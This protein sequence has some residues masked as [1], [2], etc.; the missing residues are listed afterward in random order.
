[1]VGS[2][3]RKKKMADTVTTDES[4]K[5][6]EEEEGKLHYQDTTPATITTG[7]EDK[8]A[9]IERLKSGFRI[10]KPQGTFLWPSS[11]SSTTPSPPSELVLRLHD[12]LVSPTPPSVSSSTTS[13]PLLPTSP[14][15]L[16]AEKRPVTLTILPT[17]AT[18]PTHPRSVPMI[19]PRSFLNLNEVPTNP[20]IGDCNRLYSGISNDNSDS[21]PSNSSAALTYKR[22]QHSSVLTPSDSA[23]IPALPVPSQGPGGALE[24]NAY[25][26][27]DD[28]RRVIMSS[29]PVDCLG[30]MP[31][32][33]P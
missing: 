17:P 21:I 12:L 15:K 22:R 10:C 28:A 13:P 5:G 24:M 27:I 16:L 26:R 11:S 25:R 2:E 3:E 32:D 29:D 9:K 33:R 31:W 20:N 4:E 1:G 23:S 7:T 18:P 14:V 8:T 6:L 30:A 19:S